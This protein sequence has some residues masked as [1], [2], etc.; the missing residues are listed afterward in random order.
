MSGRLSELGLG[1]GVV[2]AL[3][4]GFA[5]PITSSLSVAS[6]KITTA[7]GAVTATTLKN[8]LS[9]TGSGG[10]LDMLAVASANGTSKTM[11]LRVVVDGVEIFNGAT[12]TVAA[13]HSFVLLGGVISGTPT[14][15]LPDPIEWTS[16]L[17]IQYTSSVTETDG[18]NISYAYKLRD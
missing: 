1:G 4:C 13:T 11:T 10:Q 3:P 14:H 5:G 9:I 2:K 16:S 8:I 12:A 7:S 15:L 18:A 6:P 17:L